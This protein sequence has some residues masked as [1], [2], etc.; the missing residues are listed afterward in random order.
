[1]AIRI[2]EKNIYLS[3]R[4]L[5]PAA[6]NNP[7]LS[8]FPLPQRGAMGLKAQTWLQAGKNRKQGLFHSE[9]VINRKYLYSGYSFYI[10]GRI[11]GVYQLSN[12]VEIEEIKSVLLKKNEFA[13]VTT[14]FYPHFCEQLLLYAYLLQDELNGLEIIAYLVIINLIDYKDRVFVVNFN[15]SAVEK[16]LFERF[17]A[18]INKVETDQVERNLRKEQIKDIDFSLPESRPQQEKMMRAVQAAISEKK[19]L[20]VSA[21][22]GTGKT[23]ASLIPAVRNA[24]RDGLRVMFVTS[25]TTQQEIVKETLSKMVDQGLDLK[26]SFL[27]A[28][29]KMCANEIF[30][31]HEAHCSFAKDYRS[32]LDESGLIFKL[33][34]DK[35]NNP[36]QVYEAAVGKQLCPFELNM[37]LSLQCDVVV[38]DY[39]YIFD[40]A[41]QLRKLFFTKDY[42]DWILI[43]DEAHNLYDRGRQYLSPQLNRQKIGLLINSLK[44]R[45][46]K[47]YSS[48]NKA[49]LKIDDLFESLQKE[50]EIHFPNQ[51]YFETDL[52]LLIWQEHFLFFESAYL[53]YLIFKIR[54]SI[55]IPDDP[56]ETFYFNFRRFL[57]VAR[58]KED[59]FV[60]Y[61]DAAD[62]G[63]LNI[64][65]L[66]PSRYLSEKINSFH[67]VIAMSAT[68]D[69]MD[70]YKDVLGFSDARTETLQLDSPFPKH[71]RKIIILPHIS[72]RFKDR[73]ANYHKIAEIIKDVISIKKGNYLVFFPSYEFMQNV[74]IF[75]GN[76]DGEK[77]IQKP[78]MNDRER[79]GVIIKLRETET[80]HLLMAVTGGIFAE[81]IDYNGEMAIGVLVISPSLPRFGYERELLNRYYEN[82]NGSGKAYAY[83]YPGMNKVIQAVGRLIRSYT[84]K[85]IILL[86]GER[87]AEDEFN[88][89]LPEYWLDKKEDLIITKHYKKTIKTFWRNVV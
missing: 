40:P 2:E 64:Q 13:K 54:R 33:L 6:Q 36:D 19:H 76:I 60:T 68:L 73:K 15:R 18:I 56:L 27:R 7:V 1:M 77:I 28:A 49:L 74:N 21:P 89:L 23:A 80:A 53:A 72:T 41:A 71:N 10:S 86:I 52:N 16:F 61:Y 24:Y 83:L 35:V 51:Q 82:R 57:Q 58:Y 37:D 47:V 63:L 79:E 78:G 9:Y 46:D 11:D 8:S 48:L 81:G 38:G 25:K 70:Y 44:K 4:D 26:I 50:G 75:V 14:D 31:C 22:T 85:G 69:P 62:N 87:F 42:Q 55:L 59:S 3:V 30:F 66:D 45:K 67:S 84:D 34:E 65:C 32:R 39:N 29:K 12:R 43:I 5:V 17:R 88:Q 20:L